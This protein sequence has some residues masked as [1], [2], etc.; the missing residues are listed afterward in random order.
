MPTVIFAH[1]WYVIHFFLYCYKLQQKFH[2]C[3][4]ICTLYVGISFYPVIFPQYIV[5]QG[6]QITNELAYDKCE[7]HY[8]FTKYTVCGAQAAASVLRVT[9]RTEHTKKLVIWCVGRKCR[10]CDAKLRIAILYDKST[11]CLSKNT[12]WYFYRNRLLYFASYWFLFVINLLVIFI[13][14]QKNIRIYVVDMRYERHN[15]TTDIINVETTEVK[16]TI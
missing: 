14:K 15:Q 6:I 16:N 8:K 10:I 4:F 11:R 5:Y 12:D 3:I 7:Q 9:H 13:N 2:A 1:F